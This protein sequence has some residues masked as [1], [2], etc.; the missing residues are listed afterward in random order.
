MDT[1]STP[2]A[3]LFAF[4]CRYASHTSRFEMSN[5][6][7][8]DFSP[9]TRF[10]PGTPVDQHRQ[11]TDDPAPSL[12]PHYKGFTTTTSRSA[13]APSDGTQS[14]AAAV[15]WDTPCRHQRFPAAVSGRAFPRSTREQQSRLTSPSMPDTAWP[16]GSGTRQAHPGNALEIPVAMSLLNL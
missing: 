13:S 14:L 4:T 6:L 5:D 7:P 8:C 10:L 2:A 11:T 12:H 16:A 9:S 1:P 3:P 15:A